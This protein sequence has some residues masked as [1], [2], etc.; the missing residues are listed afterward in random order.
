MRHLL[1]LF[2]RCGLAPVT[3]SAMQPFAP[4]NREQWNKA[5]SKKLALLKSH[6]RD[7]MASR[8]VKPIGLKPLD[9]SWEILRWLENI[10][11]EISRLI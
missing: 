4:G 6:N 2:N 8:T 5:K 11:K 7:I 1:Q 10:N 3:N 9:M